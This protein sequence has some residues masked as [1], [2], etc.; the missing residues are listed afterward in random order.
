MKRL[1]YANAT[2][3]MLLFRCLSAG[4]DFEPDYQRGRVWTAEDQGRLLESIFMGA[5]IGKFV[6]RVRSTCETIED[7]L[8][9]EIIDGKQRLLTLLDFYAGRFPYQ[10]VFFNDLD[11]VDQRTFKDTSV[12]IAD[13]EN[14]TRDD[15]LKIFLLLNRGGRPV[16]DDVIRHAEELLEKETKK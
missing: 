12:C 14:Y 10:G 4:I 3:E 9:Y 16:S 8:N 5:E 2:I 7:G 6:F 13:V 1:R 15:I 11:P